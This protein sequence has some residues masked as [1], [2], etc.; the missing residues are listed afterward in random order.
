MN[1]QVTKW[2]ENITE[3]EQLQ[4][5]ERERKRQRERER[6]REKH[7]PINPEIIMFL[8]L[9]RIWISNAISHGL[10]TIMFS[11]LW[12][13]VVVAYIDGITINC[14]GTAHPSG[15]PEFTPGV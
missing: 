13:E 1:V 6:E 10:S 7:D 12:W 2:K 15:A 14:E 8:F 3:R 9:A 5:I 4:I 11:E